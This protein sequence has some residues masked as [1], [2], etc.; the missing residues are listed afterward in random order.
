MESL[1]AGVPSNDA[2]AVAVKGDGRIASDGSEHFAQFRMIDVNPLEQSYIRQVRL[3][4]WSNGKLVNAEEYTLR[5][6]MYFKNELLL[7]LK[8]AGFREVT[9]HGDYTDEHPT[10]NH[11]E[12]V[13]TAIR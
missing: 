11:D 13:F 9:V 8:V 6:D 7:M 5:G 10:A 1:V 12:L 4:K 2:T 3:E